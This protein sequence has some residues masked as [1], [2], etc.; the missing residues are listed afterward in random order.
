MFGNFCSL[1]SGS[2]LM[3]I[4][5]PKIAATTVVMCLGAS[6]TCAQSP[7]PE[8]ALRRAAAN[9]EKLRAAELEYTYRQNVL[10]QTIG[11]AGRITDEL[12]RVSDVITDD[13]GNRTEKILEYPPS[14]LA[15][16]L[17][18]AR[19]DFKSLVGL[20]PFFLT[21]NTLPQYSIKF[22]E[23]EKIGQSDTYVFDVEPVGPRPKSTAKD[24]RPFS[25]R[26][27][28][29]DREFQIVKVEGKAV[30]AKDDN[31]AFP[32]FEYYRAYVDQKWWLPSAVLA[33]DVLEFKRFDLSIKL[34]IKYTDYKR[35]KARK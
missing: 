15:M 18:I 16:R 26:I 14:R 25:G 28:I 20:D 23:R 17:G 24:D 29:D 10:V 8:E 11:Q 33:R 34:E 35:L 31:N 13:L 12:R 32:R 6:L 4:S 3:N 7:A 9:E 22:V 21:P 5:L 19:P 1:R 27:W 2:L 30:A